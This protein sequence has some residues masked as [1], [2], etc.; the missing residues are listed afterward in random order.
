MANNAEPLERLIDQFSRFPGIGRKG[1]TRM[2][3]QVMG[4]SDAEVLELSGA[5][6]DAKARL[7]RC[8]CCQNFTESDLCSICSSP[9][10]DRSVICVVESPRD[11]TAIERTR[12]YNGMY[13]VL[14]GLISPMDGIGADQLCVKELLARL[15]TGEVKEVIMATSPTVEGEATAMYLA[16]LVKPL[17]VKATRLAYG[18]PVG[19]SLE[20]AD[21]TTLYRAISGRGEL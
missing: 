13:H 1:A 11:V 9:K 4:M 7:H 3:Y 5:I 18:L 15:G 17:G 8:K 20:Y 2:A 12:E 21:E 14:H 16:K 6:R 19:S 10:R